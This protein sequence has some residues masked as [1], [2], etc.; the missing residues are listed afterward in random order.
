MSKGTKKENQPTTTNDE[1]SA[2]PKQILTLITKCATEKAVEIFDAK[3]AERRERM[4]DNR[5]KNT[6]LILKKYRSLKSYAGN[7]VSELT[8]LLSEEEV[9]YLESM[10][11]DN[12]ESQKVESIKDRVMF[13]NTVMGHVDTMLNLYKDKC[14][15]P[16]REDSA[17]R[18]RVLESMYLSETYMT[19]EEIAEREYINER[20][21]FKDLDIAVGDLAGLF[22]GIDLSDLIWL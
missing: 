15:S 20:T 1:Y 16:G 9:V 6:K 5:K 14:L 8:Q 4:K 13:T 19:A 3:T 18:W 10:G 7:A 12:L 22:F 21:V 11:M 2:I 17:R